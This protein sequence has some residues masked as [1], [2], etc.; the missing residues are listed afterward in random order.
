MTEN[1]KKTGFF[2]RI[3]GLG[4]D[5]PKVDAAPDAA[6]ENFNAPQ[7]TAQAPLIDENTAR[8]AAEIEAAKAQS[9]LAEAELQEAKEREAAQQAAAETLAREQAKAAAAKAA[10]L[11]AEK[12][13][14][15][16][17]EK[18]EAAKAEATRQKQQ[19]EAAELAR[20]EALRAKA[21]A[22]KLSWW[23]RLKQGLAKTASSVSDGI[24]SLFTKRKLD[25]GMLEDLEDILIQ[26]DLGIDVAAR[27][28]ATVGK[29]RY[30]KEI[31][32]EEVKAI[33]ATEVSK[34][35]TPVALPLV[36]DGTKSPFVILMVGVNGS[37]KTTTIGK[38]AAKFR[39]EKRSV[40][41][42][43][44]DTFRAA[45]IEQLKV[46]GERTGTPVVA[47]EQGGD[48]AGLA[49]DALKQAKEAG[50]NVLMIDTA[51]RLQNRTELMDELEKVVRVIKKQDTTAPH[52]VLLVLDATV[53]QN[54]LSQVDI[55]GKTAGVTGLVM[56]KLDGT[57]RGGILV[58]IADKFKLPIHFIGVGEGIDDLEPFAAEDFAR[59]IAGMERGNL[60]RGSA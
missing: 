43:A 60:E 59:A 40:M 6:L 52:A 42:A 20:N 13:Q 26:A 9:L 57:A 47:R 44:G 10:E 50:T 32:P 27:I 21:A 1:E 35:L 36:V 45:A 37:G 25:A 7:E 46:W 38:L 19:A 18:A 16:Q 48:A 3:F 5:Q 4:K 58:A 51:G 14:L 28:A 34:V 39:F 31:E 22:P 23:Q 41:L 17:A 33:L 30:D 53:G 24:T 29:G 55:F 8:I 56:T 12:Q 11:E 54:A 15:E 49:F 2:K